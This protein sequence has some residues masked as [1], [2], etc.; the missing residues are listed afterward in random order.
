[1]EQQGTTKRSSFIITRAQGPRLS[2]ENI[3]YA[4]EILKRLQEEEAERGR[5]RGLRLDGGAACRSRGGR[6]RWRRRRRRRRRSNR[7]SRCRDC[8]NYIR[9]QVRRRRSYRYLCMIRHSTYW[10]RRPEGGMCRMMPGNW[11]T[12]R[13]NHSTRSGLFCKSCTA[14]IQ[15]QSHQSRTSR[16]SPHPSRGVGAAADS[17]RAACADGGCAGCTVDTLNGRHYI[18]KSIRWPMGNQ[19]GLHTRSTTIRHYKSSH[20]ADSHRFRCKRCIPLS[21]LYTH[22]L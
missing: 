1:M 20:N 6:R 7:C 12:P 19:R 18:H 16:C 2:Q 15:Q 4:L 21:W 13:D 10:Y 17:G 8:N 3:E 9:L 14:P 11:P 5:G 22:S